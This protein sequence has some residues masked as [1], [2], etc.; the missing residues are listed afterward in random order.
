MSEKYSTLDGKINLTENDFWWIPAEEV[1]GFN[2]EPKRVM[3]KKSIEGGELEG[4]H[5]QKEC[6]YECDRLNSL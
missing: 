3:I 1:D 2:Y 5:Q 4:Y 6:Q